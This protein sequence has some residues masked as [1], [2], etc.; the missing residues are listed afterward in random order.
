M[1]DSDRIVAIRAWVVGALPRGPEPEGDLLPEVVDWRRGK[2]SHPL[3]R[4]P[5][6]RDQ[7]S[8]L[9]TGRDAGRLVIVEAESASGH[10]GIGL[11]NGGVAA[12]ALIELNLA[13]LVEGWSPFAHEAVWDRMFHGTLAYGRKGLA[14]H[15]LSA[16]DL[17]VWDLHGRIAGEP[18]WSLL[19]GPLHQKVPV[20]GTGPDAGAM[21]RLGM[22]GS[23]LPLTW[24]PSEGEEGFR[25]NV[26]RARR[27][28]EATAE[29]YP[30]FMD[31]WM[32][33]DL[34]YAVRL[35]H[36]L[37]DLGFRWIEEPLRPDDYA[38]H[39]ELRR[40]MPP[41]MT[42]NTGE[43]EYTAAGFRL[44]CE[45]GVDILQP[46]P[47][48]CGGLTELR[49]IAAVAQAYGKRVIPHV[50][51]NYTFHFLASYADTSFGEVAVMAGKG[52]TLSPLY[53][54][55]LTGELVPQD[56]YVRPGEAP[57]FGFDLVDRD[58]LTR[59]VS[60]ERVGMR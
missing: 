25:N 22:K 26:E 37:A 60:R 20:Y 40:R 15:A 6:F 59:P 16:V 4:Y 1:A 30:L 50:G 21:R 12:A 57:G 24:G 45:A 31:C 2:V 11:S 47:S 23:K 55:L 5:E 14:L 53:S 41:K 35:A 56:G 3:T 39:A 34:D 58:L 48:W 51:S 54:G 8:A 44:L 19:G 36:A 17:A 10:V 43:H 38:G 9:A 42:L 27:A 28:R 33:L 32:S 18:V 49:R 52:D 7:R 13:E 46:D 29:D